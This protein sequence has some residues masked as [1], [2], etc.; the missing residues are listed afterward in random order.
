[1]GGT[2]HEST[3][4]TVK[5]QK[6]LADAGLG[7]R[8]T[9]EKWIAAGRIRVD[10]ELA[11]LG[12]RV[13]PTQRV[14]LDGK[15]VSRHVQSG[16][17]M[18]LMNKAAGVEVTRKS[19]TDR[20]TVFAQ[21]P[22]LK[23]GRWISVG[24]LDV[25]TTG[26]LLFTNNGE[27]ANKLMH[28]STNLDREYAVRVRSL[29]NDETLERLM[30]GVE[31]NG[32]TCRFTDIQ[33]Y[34]GRGSN[35]WYHV[36]LMEGRNREVRLLF[37]SQGIMVSRLKRVRFG[38]FIAPNFV[39]AGRVVEIHSDEVNAVCEMLGLSIQ[40]RSRGDSK[41]SNTNRAVLIPYPNLTLP[42]WYR[43]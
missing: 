1:M 27:L 2:T 37:E 10:G 29:L 40:T 9:I 18:L 4:S 38:P 12:D 33:Y 41:P 14:E 3:S 32:V 42:R 20:R 5:L 31:I 30:R 17:R 8:R 25:G 39:P 23:S 7:S 34:D 35:H 6:A 28:P 19:A 15:L 16:P 36:C 21:L 22:K 11:T 43:D 26:L 13:T 24:R